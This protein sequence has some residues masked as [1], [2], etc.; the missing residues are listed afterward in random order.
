M[1][2]GH[3][4]T[5]R[6]ARKLG[7]E[8]TLT[9]FDEAPL[10]PT[11]GPSRLP[12]L[13]V[14]SPRALAEAFA[15]TSAPRA[16]AFYERF[17]DRHVVATL[18][19]LVDAAKR[20]HG[21]TRRR[22]R[23]GERDTELAVAAARS[24][25]KRGYVQAVLKDVVQLSPESV[26]SAHHAK[27]WSARGRALLALYKAVRSK[28]LVQASSIRQ[29]ALVREALRCF[30]DELERAATRSRGRP[31]T[32]PID[33]DFARLSIAAARR[34]HATLHAMSPARKDTRRALGELED[35]FAAALD[36][37]FVEIDGPACSPSRAEAI[38]DG[39]R[40]ALYEMLRE[41]GF[42]ALRDLEPKRGRATEIGDGSSLAIWFVSEWY[43]VSE[44]TAKRALRGLSIQERRIVARVERH[45]SGHSL[46]HEST[47]SSDAER[48]RRA[49]ARRQS[50][51]APEH[52]P[53]SVQRAPR[54]LA[55]RRPD[56]EGSE[57]ARAP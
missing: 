49:P 46:A 29:R 21:K 27:Q 44:T 17:V 28:K 42:P 37:Y 50:R 14:T 4:T 16:R 35:A 31:R 6:H 26:T 30:V 33:R 5:R 7:K 13:P 53:S 12:A 45:E 40:P 9:W 11:A 57:S 52:H 34:A 24:L 43:A 32:R 41:R 3:D 54:P 20:R 10:G 1:A 2:D 47:P 15:P 48:S 38:A 56:R 8:D 19:S 51:A 55:N 36:E 25:V 22:K 39:V 18:Q 23:R